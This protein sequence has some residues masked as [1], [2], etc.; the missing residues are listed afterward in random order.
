MTLIFD[1]KL[2]KVLPFCHNKNVYQV[3]WSKIK[4]SLYRLYPHLYH[5]K[6]IFFLVTK[7]KIPAKFSN[8]LPSCICGAPP[9]QNFI[10]IHAML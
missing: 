10:P 9:V 7:S 8:D 3:W 6:Y 5:T 2:K 4:F 1:L